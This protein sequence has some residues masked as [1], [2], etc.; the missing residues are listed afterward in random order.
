[1]L[2]PQERQRHE[3]N[4][5]IAAFTVSGGTGF[6]CMCVCVHAHTI[7]NFIIISVIEYSAL[8]RIYDTR[9]HSVYYDALLSVL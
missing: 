6:V 9:R 7:A 3:D 4:D 2:Y 1:M 8:L 5:Y